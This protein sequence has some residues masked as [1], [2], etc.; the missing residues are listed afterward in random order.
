MIRRA[1]AELDRYDDDGLPRAANGSARPSER[2]PHVRM[3]ASL[4]PNA[5]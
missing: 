1:I 4:R 3:S 5:E 2:A